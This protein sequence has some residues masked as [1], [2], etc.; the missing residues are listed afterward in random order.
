MIVTA[1]KTDIWVGSY[2]LVQSEFH[3]QHILCVYISGFYCGIELF[4][5]SINKL[6][7]C[8]FGNI[9]GLENIQNSQ[10]AVYHHYSYVFLA[11]FILFYFW[12]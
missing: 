12:A 6:T 7:F 1:F 2:H 10:S 8:F 11:Y 4:Y 3:N 9:H 5:F